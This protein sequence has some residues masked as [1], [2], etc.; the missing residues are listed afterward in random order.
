M[1]ASKVAR[2]DNLQS[3]CRTTC[4][5]IVIG[6][7]AACGELI[8]ATASASTIGLAAAIYA[9][10]KEL[11]VDCTIID[12]VIA[13]PFP[14]IISAVTSTAHP[15]IV[16]WQSQQLSTEMMVIKDLPKWKLHHPNQLV[17]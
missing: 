17:R 7:E 4:D 13:G 11:L 16:L 14:G 12:A 5:A 6:I 3:D 15:A 8:A 9:A 10:L 1:V 2:I